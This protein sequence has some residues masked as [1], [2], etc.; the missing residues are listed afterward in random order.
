MSN[1]KQSSIEWFLDQ[2]TYDNGYGQRRCSFIDTEDLISY[3]EQAKA[4]HKEE[5][6][7]AITF[8]QNN[9]SVSIPCD[10]LSA[11]QYYNET[12]GGDNEN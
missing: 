5:M 8:G 6:I 2:I 10:K 4:M 9:H 7:E 11:E 3:F 12:F 1:D